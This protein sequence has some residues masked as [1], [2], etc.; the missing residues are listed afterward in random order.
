MWLGIV[1]LNSL[2]VISCPD[3]TKVRGR[4]DTEASVRIEKLLT[5]LGTGATFVAALHA[6]VTVILKKT[7]TIIRI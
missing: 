5:H 7:E 3:G 1:F 6:V 2:I 4:L